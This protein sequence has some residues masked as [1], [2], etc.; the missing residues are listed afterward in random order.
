M[1][2][3]YSFFI[4]LFVSANAFAGSSEWVK[5]ENVQARI[6]HEK[7]QIF[8]EL[9]PDEGWH[10]YYKNP[11]DAGW[12]TEF[13]WAG[14]TDFEVSE[15]Q[16][17]EPKI[18][19]EFGIKTNVYYGGVKFPVVAE[20]GANP[21]IRLNLKGAVCNEVCVPFDI[22]LQ[23]ANFVVKPKNT[24]QQLLNL[25]IVWTALLA[26]LILNIMPCV[27]PVLSLKVL[28]LVKQSGA[29]KRHARANFVASAAGVIFSFL[30]LAAG[31]AVLKASG[32]TLGWGLH[33]QS[34]YF[35]GGLMVITTIFALSLFGFFHLRVPSWI[36]DKGANANNLV[37]NF[38]AGML[39]TLLGT[40][41][42]APVLVSAVGFALAGSTAQIFIIF[43]LM[44][45]GMA[46]P[47]L[48]FAARPQLAKFLPKPGRWMLWVKNLMAL[49]LLATAAW[50]GSILYAQ[51]STA[52]VEIEQA[53][54]SEIN[55]QNFDEQEIFAL[56]EQ[57]KTVF[58]DITAKWCVS[59]HVNKLNVLQTKD[60]Q[61]VLTQPDV[62]A[63]R[64]DMTRPS[65]ALLQYIRKHD[66]TGIP[67]NAVYG[68]NVASPTEP[69]LLEPILS[70]DAVKDALLAAK[71]K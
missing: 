29:E 25:S 42:T 52:T 55:W 39:A 11:G 57:G 18:H 35:V 32:E 69:I 62:V 17:P 9:Q 67:F 43:G 48:L 37:G 20:I 12:A 13:N 26:G 15:V 61:E 54:N 70:T 2:K 58:V 5:S 40:A 49:M 6:V 36:S 63:M 31:A 53:E 60:I 38:V 47:Y 7:S 28:S 66:R 8:V 33:F 46:L 45:V 65:E 41:C 50:L 21:S 68:P 22:N 51:T 14:S 59:C 71:K 10:S 19:E 64:G 4:F 44:G 16:F 30:L 27:L 56:V 3:I 23:F 24:A 1:L 34:P